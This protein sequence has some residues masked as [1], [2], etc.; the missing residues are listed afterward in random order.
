MLIQ[1]TS[2]PFLVVQA[3]LAE[4]AGAKA[5]ALVSVTDGCVMAFK[6][7]S[8][9]SNNPEQAEECLKNLQFTAQFSARMPRYSDEK[10][11]GM[12]LLCGPTP[13]IYL[14][15]PTRA[16]GY[17]LCLAVE[18]TRVNAAATAL[19]RLAA[20]YRP[21]KTGLRESSDPAALL[22]AS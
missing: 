16:A 14:L 5:A 1:N 10:F 18:P 8:T 13:C 6:F 4:A 19:R 12:E 21:A 17:A 20:S 9:I 15:R 11:E 3:V 2:D 7:A 22:I